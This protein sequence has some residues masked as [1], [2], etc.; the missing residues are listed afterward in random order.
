MKNIVIIGGGTGTFTLL[1]GLRKYPSNNTVIVSSADDGGSTGVLRRDLGIFP[2]G[3]L[4]QCLVGLS[5][6]DKQMTELFSYRFEKG[7]LKGHTVGN[8]ILAALEKTTGNIETA[9]DLAAKLLNVR[10]SVLPASLK[11]GLLIAYLESG[12]RVVGE[13]NIDQPHFRRSRIK[14]LQLK[15]NTSANPKAMAALQEADAIVFGPGDLYTSIVPNLLV[16]GIREAL[17]K[18]RAKK[19]LITNIMTKAGQTDGFKASDFARN[20]Q[21][22]LGVAKLNYAIVNNQKPSSKSILA[23]KKENAKF[24]EPDVKQ[25]ERLGVKAHQAKLVSQV[26]Y[27]KKTADKLNRS[28]LR[29]DASKTAKLIWNLIHQS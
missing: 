10:G 15:P 1:S 4:R 20:L 3:D 12:K 25:M 24:V 19:I 28:L 2:P 26:I 6:T 29:H 14:S 7:S 18:S 13:H 17:G 5:Y 21:K 27:K 16:K 11:P 8:I 9:V 22:Y 23:Y